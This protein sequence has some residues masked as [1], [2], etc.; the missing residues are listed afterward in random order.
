MNEPIKFRSEIIVHNN[1]DVD[2][3]IQKLRVDFRYHDDT[4]VNA[5]VDHHSSPRSRSINIPKS[6]NS[7]EQRDKRKF[8]PTTSSPPQIL[9]HQWIDDICANEQLMSNDDIVFFIKNGEFFARI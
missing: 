4:P 2:L 8:H 5:I 9:L 7:H 3:H 6:S 1:P